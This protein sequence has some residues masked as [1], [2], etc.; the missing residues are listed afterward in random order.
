[1]DTPRFQYRIDRHHGS[2]LVLREAQDN[3]AHS[4][5]RVRYAVRQ[6]DS[7]AERSGWCRSE[8]SA[9]LGAGAL[10]D[11]SP[12][13]R[14]PPLSPEILMRPRLRFGR[15]H[16]RYVLP[17]ASSES[18]PAEGSVQLGR[19]ASLEIDSESLRTSRANALL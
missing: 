16:H 19:D 8:A 18:M 7:S 6:S 13:S 15:K 1:M 17:A 11:M 5:L 9:E 14:R 12:R 2:T 3:E 10:P 4:P